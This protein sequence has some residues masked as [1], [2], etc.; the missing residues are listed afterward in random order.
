MTITI[1]L[2]GVA[3][4]AL[5]AAGAV[6]FSLRKLHGTVHD[7]VRGEVVKQDDR[8]RKK[9]APEDAREPSEAPKHPFAGAG[10][11]ALLAGQ[12]IDLDKD[13]YATR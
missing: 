5:S 13:G 11:A 1:L 3:L 2:I 6:T 9:L 4:T 8:I 12:S 7:I 10:S